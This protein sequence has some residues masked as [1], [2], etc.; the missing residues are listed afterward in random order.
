MESPQTPPKRDKVT[1]KEELIQVW[2]LSGTRFARNRVETV[3]LEP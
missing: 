3:M 2:D 1:S